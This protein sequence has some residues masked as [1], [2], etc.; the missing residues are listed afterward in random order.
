MYLLKD[1]LIQIWFMANINIYGTLF[2]N[3]TEGIIANANQ[4]YDTEYN[5]G[6]FQSTINQS[7]STRLESIENVVGTDGIIDCGEYKPELQ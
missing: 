7:F 1:D 5:E 6:E 3:T 4:L 2:N